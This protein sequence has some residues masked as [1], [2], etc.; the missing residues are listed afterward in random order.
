MET[1]LDYLVTC[2]AG[3]EYFVQVVKKDDYHYEATFNGCTRKGADAEIAVTQ[4]AAHCAW[5]VRQVFAATPVESF[6]RRL[7]QRIAELNLPDD[8]H[9]LV[10][11]AVQT[12]PA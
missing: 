11:H 4:L 2:W 1:S 10:M 9:D 6:K 3:A 7:L 8:E 12:T 5:G